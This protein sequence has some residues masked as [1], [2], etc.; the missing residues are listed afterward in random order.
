M[1]TLSKHVLVITHDLIKRNE[2]Y[3]KFIAMSSYMDASDYLQM[4]HSVPVP[5]GLQEGW[6][7]D[8]TDMAAMIWQSTDIEEN[9][10]N[11]DNE[12]ALVDDATAPETFS[13]AVNAVSGLVQCCASKGLNEHANHFL[14]ARDCLNDAII[15]AVSSRLSVSRLDVA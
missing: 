6:E 9:D 4:A 3:A 7:D 11:D 2:F 1:I 8:M 14:S 10:S 12:E 5:E 15:K 13:E